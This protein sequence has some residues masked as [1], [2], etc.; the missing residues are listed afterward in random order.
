MSDR[1]EFDWGSWKRIDC[2]EALS[3]LV[4]LKVEVG[5][6]HPLWNCL[7]RTEVLARDSASDD[8]LIEITGTSGVALFVVHLTWSQAV[9]ANG[10]F[11]GVAELG[12][13]AVPSELRSES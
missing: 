10:V 13:A 7:H 4:Q 8:V 6:R 5:R 1:Q 3:L 12:V 9:D 11:P 2:A